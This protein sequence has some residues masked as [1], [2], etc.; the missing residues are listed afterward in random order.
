MSLNKVKL[1]IYVSMHILD[2]YTTIYT[3]HTNTRAPTE[4]NW[5][6]LAELLNSETIYESRFEP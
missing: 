6:A 5:E 4:L 3:T 1:C 2:T